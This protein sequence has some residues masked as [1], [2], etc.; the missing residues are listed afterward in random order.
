MESML[1]PKAT[2]TA[3]LYLRCVGLHMSSIRLCTPGNNLFKAAR[4]FANWCSRSDS[5]RSAF[6]FMS[7]SLYFSIEAFSSPI[8]RTEVVVLSPISSNSFC[9]CSITCRRWAR[10]FANLAFL[11]RQ[12]STSF[13]LCSLRLCNSLILDVYE[14][15]SSLSFCCRVCKVVISACTIAVRFPA[16]SFSRSYSAACSSSILSSVCWE[17]LCVWASNSPSCWF[18]S[19]RSF[20]SSSIV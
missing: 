12:S 19:A 10:S 2:V 5:L 14:A 15:S 13:S 9:F 6:A 18:T 11:S 17:A 1:P 7:W 16:S 4:V 3:T 8:R 20:P